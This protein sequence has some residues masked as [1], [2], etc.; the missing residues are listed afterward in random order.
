MFGCSSLYKGV[1]NF[2]VRFFGIEYG[3]EKFQDVS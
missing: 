3:V 2:F 1:R